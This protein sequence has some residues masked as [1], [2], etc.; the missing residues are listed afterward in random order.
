MKIP[1]TPLGIN[2]LACRFQMLGQCIPVA[3]CMVPVLHLLAAT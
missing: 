2:L 3:Y 1:M